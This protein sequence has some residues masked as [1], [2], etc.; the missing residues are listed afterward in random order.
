MNSSKNESSQKLITLFFIGFC[1]FLLAACGLRQTSLNDAGSTEA[2]NFDF[3]LPT[4]QIRVADGDTIQIKAF[5]QQKPKQKDQ[6]IRLLN[7]DAPELAQKPFGENS[8]Q[9]LKGLLKSAK[10]QQVC[11]KSG[12]NSRD[13]YGRLLAYC[14]SG[15]LFLNAQMVKDGQAVAYFYGTTPSKYKDLLLEYEEQAEEEGLGIHDPLNKLEQLPTEFR[16]ANRQNR[17]QVKL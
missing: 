17:R 3:C 6:R 14:W 7:I 9:H 16:K 10:S 13:K 12:P 11:C 15:D 1:S 4:Q 5:R 2:H 8:K